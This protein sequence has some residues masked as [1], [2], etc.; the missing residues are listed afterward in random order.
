[1]LKKLYRHF[2]S[3]CRNYIEDEGEFNRRWDYL[4]VMFGLDDK[5]SIKVNCD[6]DAPILATAYS[7]MRSV[8][9]ANTEIHAA[10][11]DYTG[12]AKIVPSECWS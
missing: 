5:A 6:P 9:P 4:I 10:D 7:R 1:M 11:H 3:Q 2:L 8:V 12:T